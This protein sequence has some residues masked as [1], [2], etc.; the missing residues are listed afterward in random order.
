MNNKLHTILFVLGLV[1]MFPFYVKGQSTEYPL[2]NMNYGTIKD[3]YDV[4]IKE[5]EKLPGRPTDPGFV[6]LPEIEGN[7]NHYA[8]FY[9]FGDKT[10]ISALELAKFLKLNPK[11][12]THRVILGTDFQNEEYYKNGK[13][14]KDGKEIETVTVSMNSEG[15][16]NWSVAPVGTASNGN[17][18]EGS[19][20]GITGTVSTL[21]GGWFRFNTPIY[22]KEGREMKL[23]KG[24]FYTP[25]LTV[26][27]SKSR[28]S[29]SNSNKNQ[30]VIIVV[31]VDIRPP[32][33]QLEQTLKS[34]GIT[35]DCNRICSKCNCGG[36]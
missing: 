5:G 14:E 20:T 35:G 23:V 7:A 34:M 4:E 13:F 6:K 29:S 8:Y 33:L 18:G 21:S 28:E 22:D 10:T 36:R 12:S 1:L 25:H 31:G 9:D 2:T 24:A 30:I 16:Y 32:K 27:K 17:G 19:F 15:N 3:F 26:H 11:D